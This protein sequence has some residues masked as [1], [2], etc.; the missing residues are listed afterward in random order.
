MVTRIMESIVEIECA[1]DVEARQAADE[2]QR[3]L[4]R[5]RRLR[6]EGRALARLLTAAY[7]QEEPRKAA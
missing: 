6:D 7:D 2:H 4:D 5:L 3:R 1:V